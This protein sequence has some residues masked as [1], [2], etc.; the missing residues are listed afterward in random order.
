M[1]SKKKSDY[2]DMESWAASNCNTD[3][4]AQAIMAARIERLTGE[5]REGW[6]LVEKKRRGAHMYFP[7]YQIP[8][9]VEVVGWERRVMNQPGG[10]NG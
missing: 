1:V 10:R 4:E 9:N 6:T 3:L 8:M 2:K 5:L 7:P